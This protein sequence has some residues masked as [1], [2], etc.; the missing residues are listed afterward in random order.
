MTIERRSA[1]ELVPARDV[2]AI[3]AGTDRELRALEDR[4][5]SARAAA[6]AAEAEARAAGVAEGA[7]VRSM[8]ELQ[9][10]LDE[11]RVR[12][13]HDTDRL[14]DAARARAVVDRSPPRIAVAFGGTGI[15]D[16]LAADART[17]PLPAPPAAHDDDF[18][19]GDPDAARRRAR[20]WVPVSAALEVAAVIAALALVLTRLG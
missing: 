13:E 8:I 5:A 18:W 20:R 19:A 15:E 11:L 6:E 14:L 2:Q 16:P 3:V 7:S 17:E 4:L 10:V 9:Q 1:V 12:A